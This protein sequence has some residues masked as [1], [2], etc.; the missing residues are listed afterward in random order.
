[1]DKVK[2][3]WILFL[4]DDNKFLD[5]H[6]LSNISKNIDNEDDIIFWSIPLG[7]AK[8]NNVYAKMLKN[9]DMN[10]GKQMTCDAWKTGFCVHSKH[11]HK[12]RATAGHDG[13]DNFLAN[14]LKKKY[15]DQLLII[16]STSKLSTKIP[17]PH[18]V[19]PFGICETN[20]TIFLLHN[21]L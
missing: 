12:A 18:Y 7:D 3:G 13:L 21:L 20:R 14:L 15:I 9:I 10:T 17:N 1:M 16:M 19:F 8:K 11:I 5:K 2:D 4:N 6:T